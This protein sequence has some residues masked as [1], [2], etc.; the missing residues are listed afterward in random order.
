MVISTCGAG[1]HA[2]G[3]RGE[4]TLPTAARTLAGLAADAQIVLVAVPAWDLLIVDPPVLL[5]RLLAE[6]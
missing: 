4:L 6:H 1:R 2:V 3:S 5:V